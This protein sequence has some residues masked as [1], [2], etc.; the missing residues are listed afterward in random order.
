MLTIKNV[1][2]T[3]LVFGDTLSTSDKAKNLI[4]IEKNNFLLLPKTRGILCLKT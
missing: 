1:I 2:K 3:R 4:G